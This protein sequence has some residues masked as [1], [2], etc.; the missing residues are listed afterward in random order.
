[1]KAITFTRYG[2]PDLLQLEEIPT[3]TPKEDEVSVKVRA[4]SINSWDWEFQSSETLP[5]RL[6]LG[7]FK[8]RKA[9]RKLGC[10]VSGVVE[11]IGQSVSR[12]KVGDE[13]FGDLWDNFEGFAESACCCWFT[14]ASQRHQYQSEHVHFGF[15]H[16]SP[17]K[18]S[19]DPR[20]IVH[21]TD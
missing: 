15:L 9:K 14:P 13:V 16:F 20:P 21:A 6:L 12:F 19:F 4:S 5:S 2:S 7:F 1:M 17:E 3:P 8:P 18:R 11:S 10:N